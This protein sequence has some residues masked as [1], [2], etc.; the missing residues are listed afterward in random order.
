[1]RASKQGWQDVVG[2]NAK[3]PAAR[4]SAAVGLHTQLP[5][6]VVGMV[7]ASCSGPD[8]LMLEAT[9]C[10]PGGGEGRKIAAGK[11]IAL[12]VH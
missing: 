5:R 8:F 1:M 6:V 2:L 4:S 7:V 3:V 12:P 10:M 9:G 11:E